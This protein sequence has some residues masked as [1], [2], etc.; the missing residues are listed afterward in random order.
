MRCRFMEMFIMKV[1]QRDVMGLHAY[2]MSASHLIY[3]ISQDGAEE[4]IQPLKQIKENNDLGATVEFLN[5]SDTRS[6]QLQRQFS[7]GM[8]WQMPLMVSTCGKKVFRVKN[9]VDADTM[10]TLHLW[11]R[12]NVCEEA[13]T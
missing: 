5:A 4:A 11:I 12:E 2:C 10:E 3:V 1:G 8:K 9:I 7:C 13:L 6:L